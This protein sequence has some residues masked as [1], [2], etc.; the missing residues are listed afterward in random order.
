[1]AVAQKLRSVDEH[2]Q[3]VA[4]LLTAT[5]VIRLPLV[6]CAGLALAE[7]VIASLPLPP[8]DNSAMDGYAVRSVDVADA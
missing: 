1:M 6:E 2:S 5:P 3:V 4:A 8:F 7:P